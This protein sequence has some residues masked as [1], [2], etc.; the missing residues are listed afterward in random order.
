MPGPKLLIK[1]T[2]TW[3]L[4]EVAA[5]HDVSEYST[6]L[7]KTWG[8]RM[9]NDFRSTLYTMC[10]IATARVAFCLVGSL[11]HVVGDIGFKEG[12]FLIEQRSINAIY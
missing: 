5:S 10:T 2:W 7:A 12:L 4:V 8:G 11:I 1:K 6:T 3:T 9:S